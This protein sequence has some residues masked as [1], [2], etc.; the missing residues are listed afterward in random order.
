[1]MLQ[2]NAIA[3]V[4]ISEAQAYVRVET[5]EE[6]ALLAGLVRTASAVCEAFLNQVVIAQPFAVRVDGAGQWTALPVC[7]VRSIDEVRIGSR[8]LGIEEYEVDVDSSGTGWVRLAP[9]LRCT[10]AG[11]AGLAL[12]QNGVPEPIRQGVLRLVSHLYTFRDS[13]TDAPP[14]IVTALWRPFRRLVLA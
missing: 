12:D 11:T 14:A 8:T 6:E 3:I 5:G 9:G 1:M 13:G 7:P 2:A 10:V 4:T